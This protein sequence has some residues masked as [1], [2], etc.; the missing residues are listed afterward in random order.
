[1][2]LVRKDKIEVKLAGYSVGTPAAL[3]DPTLL[4]RTQ[5]YK[6]QTSQR[7]F[8]LEAA[9]VPK[10]LSSAEYH[11]SLKIDGEFSVLAYADGEAILVNPGGTVRVGLALEKEAA[12]KLKAAGIKKALFA[13]EL[14]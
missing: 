4:T 10:R 12:E 13:G 6:R 1:M 14:Y 11:V 5:D 9:D 2:S 7:M 3:V 8:P